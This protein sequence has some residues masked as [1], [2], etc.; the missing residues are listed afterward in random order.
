ML[1]FIAIAVIIALIVFIALRPRK[2][3]LKPTHAGGIVYKVQDGRKLFL[4][5][6]SSTSKYKWVLPKG[7]I[8][9]YETPQVAA[10]REVLEEAGVTATIIK[11]AG[12]VTYKKKSQQITVAYY[13]MEFNK[14]AKKSTEGRDIDWVEKAVVIKRLANKD[15]AALVQNI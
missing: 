2:A 13:V 8:D 4:M 1:W 14:Q 15:T 7:K 6:T 9:G 3:H 12:M 10:V 5:V 11:P